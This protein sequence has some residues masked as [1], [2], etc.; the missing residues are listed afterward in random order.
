MYLDL[1]KDKRLLIVFKVESNGLALQVV[2]RVLESLDFFKVNF[3]LFISELIALRLPLLAERVTLSPQAKIHK[4][5]CF[6][7]DANVFNFTVFEDDLAKK[8]DHFYDRQQ[9]HTEVVLL[10]D[11]RNVHQVVVGQLRLN[12]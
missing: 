12:E 7:K 1:F 10:Q 6:S 3:F 9:L 4:Q 11:V 2:G 5:S 8:V